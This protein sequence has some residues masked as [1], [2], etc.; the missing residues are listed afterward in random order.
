[1]RAY[2]QALVWDI[3]Q[4]QPMGTITRWAERVLNPVLGKSIIVYAKKPDRS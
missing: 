4:Q 3:T 1:V 2:H